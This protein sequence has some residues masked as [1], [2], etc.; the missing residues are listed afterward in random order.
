LKRYDQDIQDCH[1]V[2]VPTSRYRVW[3]LEELQRAWNELD[4]A[5][6]AALEKCLPSPEASVLWNDTSF[7]PSGYDSER[8]APFNRAINVFGT[9]VPPR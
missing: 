3:C 7:A 1:Y 2:G 5:A 4:N 8:L 9:G 6:R